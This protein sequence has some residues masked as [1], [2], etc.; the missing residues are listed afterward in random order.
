MFTDLISW[1]EE[2]GTA[3]VIGS[4]AI[5]LL[6]GIDCVYLLLLSNFFPFR[7]ER[8]SPFDKPH[9]HAYRGNYETF[10]WARDTTSTVFQEGGRKGVE[11]VPTHYD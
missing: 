2:E 6:V 8:H 5:N 1:T 3:K 10:L 9:S 11:V 7:S 4:S